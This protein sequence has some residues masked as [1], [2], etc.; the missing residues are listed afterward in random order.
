[1]NAL[2]CHALKQHPCTQQHENEGCCIL[3]SKEEKRAACFTR[4]LYMQVQSLACCAAE[5][6]SFQHATIITALAESSSSSLC[7]SSMRL[8]HAAF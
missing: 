4:M 8:K 7:N 6:P 1:M 5:T 2:C 3:N